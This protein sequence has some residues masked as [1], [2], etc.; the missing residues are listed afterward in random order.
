MNCR[1][2]LKQIDDGNINLATFVEGD[3]CAA[4]T[5]YIQFQA[6]F[7]SIE[8]S[9]NLINYVLVDEVKATQSG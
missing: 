9:L 5:K 1:W 6:C 2:I 3:P 8:I 4:G 7:R